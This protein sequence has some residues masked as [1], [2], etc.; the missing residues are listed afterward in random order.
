ML[1]KPP[2]RRPW[3]NCGTFFRSLFYF[4]GLLSG[5]N[6]GVSE[7]ALVHLETF[8][9]SVVSFLAIALELCNPHHPVEIVRVTGIFPKLST[10]LS[11]LVCKT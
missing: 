1:R 4:C 2:Q 11:T 7:Q 6:V 5:E 8:L 10:T 3:N 9:R